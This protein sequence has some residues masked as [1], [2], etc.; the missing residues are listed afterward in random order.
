M[1]GAQIPSHKDSINR[2]VAEGNYPALHS[3]THNYQKL[4]N[5]GQI[6]NEMKQAQAIFTGGYRNTL[7]LDSLSIR[8]HARAYK[9]TA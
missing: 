1:I 8:K 9:C 6:V 5:E 7:R 3:M 2:L 4:Y